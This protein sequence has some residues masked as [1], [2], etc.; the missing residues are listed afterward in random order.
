MLIVFEAICGFVFGIMLHSF[1]KKQKR[2]KMVSSWE[3]GDAML[4]KNKQILPHGIELIYAKLI[5]WNLDNFFCSCDIDSERTLNFICKY[6]DLEINKSAEW[7]KHFNKCSKTMGKNPSFSYNKQDLFGFD[8][9]KSEEKQ[10]KNKVSSKNYNNINQLNFNGKP[11]D[12]LTETE[13]QIYL[14]QCLEKEDYET[15][16]LIRK[17]MEKYR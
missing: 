15:A 11:I 6:E 16:V 10:L 7:R 17:Q 9:N 4:F 3:L 12:L 2:K 8:K 5:G 1:Y 14:K 13:C